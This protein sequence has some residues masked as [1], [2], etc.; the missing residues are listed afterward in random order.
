MP[1]CP[2]CRANGR[3][4]WIWTYAVNHLKTCFGCWAASVT[5]DCAESGK[6][7]Y[8]YQSLCRLLMTTLIEHYGFE[9][10]HTLHSLTPVKFRTQLTSRYFPEQ[11]TVLLK[12]QASDFSTQWQKPDPRGQQ[13]ADELGG[14]PGDVGRSLLGRWPANADHWQPC[15]HCLVFRSARLRFICA[16]QRLPNNFAQWIRLF[17]LSNGASRRLISGRFNSRPTR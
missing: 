2:C 3:E 13:G 10:R 12:Q 17:A 1:A 16:Q 15:P 8:A 9:R 6:P 7:Q 5:C 4:C 14:G 11:Q